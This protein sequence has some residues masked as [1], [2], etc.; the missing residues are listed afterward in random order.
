MKSE[1]DTAV[2]LIGQRAPMHPTG[3]PSS[4]FVEAFSQGVRSG[5][6]CKIGESVRKPGKFEVGRD[7][8]PAPAGE[9]DTRN[10]A[11]S[12]MRGFTTGFAAGG[13]IKNMADGLPSRL[14]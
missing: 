4:L 9:F 1:S 7:G 5:F 2:R 13:G 6:K 8:Y 12:Y 10:E 14:T 11:M 3:D